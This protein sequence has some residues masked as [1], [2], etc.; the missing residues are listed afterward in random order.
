MILQSTEKKFVD[1]NELEFDSQE[2]SKDEKADFEEKNRNW[3]H[4]CCCNYFDP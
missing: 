1:L 2:K 4:K 3:K